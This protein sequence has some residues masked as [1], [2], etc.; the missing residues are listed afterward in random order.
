[1]SA[2]NLVL[3]LLAEGSNSLDTLRSFR[4]S[5]RLKAVYLQAVYAVCELQWST[6]FL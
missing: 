3:V 4:I 6:S 5:N 2:S 1:M